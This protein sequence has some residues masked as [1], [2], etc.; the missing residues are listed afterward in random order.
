MA[1]YKTLIKFIEAA[2]VKTGQHGPPLT[3]WSK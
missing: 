2:L 3:Y 1:F